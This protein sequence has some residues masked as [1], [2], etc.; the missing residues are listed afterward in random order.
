[1]PDSL[2]FL[3]AAIPGVGGV[4]KT[5]PE[6]FVVEELPLYQPGGAGTHVYALMEKRGIGTR[7][8]LDRVARALN[9][10]RREI[11][12]AGVNAAPAGAPTGDRIPAPRGRVCPLPQATE[13]AQ[14]VLSILSR[15]GVPNY[16]G[17]QRFG[18][19]QDNHLLGKAVARNDAVAFTDQF[20][21]HPREIVDSP[22]VFEARRLYQQGRYEE[23][24]KAWA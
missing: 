11:G 21:G 7:E 14:E 22:P 19:H 1:M 3:T 5:R 12:S 18:N 8:A 23:A 17:P 15:R 4:I 9:F 16:F 24:A 13:M 10:S 2:P 6:D 20:L